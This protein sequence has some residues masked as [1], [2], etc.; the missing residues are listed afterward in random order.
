VSRGLHGL[1]VTVWPGFEDW[2]AAFWELGTERQ[3]GM[4]I[5]PI[6]HSAIVAYADRR[7][8]HDE[9]LFLDCIRAMDGVFLDYMAKDPKD[10]K[11]VND[12]PMTPE[13]F[14]QIFGG[15]K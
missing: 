4:S 10:R 5:G 12:K 15:G 8:W 6:P 2:L 13:K 3:I 9:A 11:R 7:G 14:A 1:P